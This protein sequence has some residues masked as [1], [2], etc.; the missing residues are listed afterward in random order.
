MNVH[1]PNFLVAD[2]GGVTIGLGQ[3]KTH[4]D[5]SRE[6]ASIAVVPE[7]RHEGIASAIIKTLLARETEDVLYLTCQPR[8]EGYYQRFGFRRIQ[9]ADYPPY[10][11][12]F[13]PIFNF[14]ANWFGA[15][16]LVMRKDSGRVE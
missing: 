11:R 10:F 13:M 12:R 6:L 1:W 16:I 5:G 8:L 7:R 14:V 3:V 2:E 4:R 15:Q 9:R